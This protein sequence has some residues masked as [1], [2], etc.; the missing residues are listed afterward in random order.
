MNTK[1][2]KNLS[3]RISQRQSGLELL[4]IIAMIM[5]VASHLSQRGNWSW[6]ASSEPLTTN[7]F[8]MNIVICFGQVGVAIFFSITGYFLYNSKKHNWKR[9]LKIT[10]PTWFYSLSFLVFA[11]IFCPSLIQFSIP[12]NQTTAHLLFPITT[13]AYWFISA[14]ISLYLL[15]P[16]LKIWLDSLDDKKLFK[17]ILIIAGI[18]IIPNILSYS[19]AD[20]S[21]FIFAIP[22]AIFYTIVGYVIH[23]CKNKLIRL[24]N[25]K[26]LFISLSGVSI[27]IISSLLIY[28]AA[29]RLSYANINNNILIDTMSLPCM[30]TSIPLVI[31]FSRLKFV[32]RFINYLAGLVFG[33]YL[34][35][36]NGVFINLF[37]REHDILHT[38]T[39]SNY[40][41]IHF[42][43]YFSLTVLII[44][45]LSAVIEALRKLL[46]KAI[47]K[48]LLFF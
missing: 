39:A 10:R 15:L 42:I 34:V 21:S 41:P 17:L 26:L 5:I 19:L 35:H 14:Y 38:A 11:L 45:C 8:I 24:Q 37:W 2:S 47:S 44:F 28:L 25:I 27:F 20:M 16:Y 6:L 33:I 3:P 36:S 18:F 12:F 13:N 29:T 32:N 43:F 31:L 9:I 48:L 1:I 46:T 22:S 30:L 23:R 7:Q 4:R 40:S